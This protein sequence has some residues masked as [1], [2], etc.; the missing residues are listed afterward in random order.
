MIREATFGHDL[1]VALTIDRV[2]SLGQ[3]N[4]GR[5][6]QAILLLVFLLPSRE[7]HVNCTTPL[8]D[9]ALAL[10]K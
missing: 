2:K 7:H 10:W 6:E 1:A 8:S 5:V 4:E 3:V 9:A